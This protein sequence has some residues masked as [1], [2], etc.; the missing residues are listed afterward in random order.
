MMLLKGDDFKPGYEEVA[1]LT[2]NSGRIFIII[3]Q[4]FLPQIEGTC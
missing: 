1:I 4:D 2:M 3:P